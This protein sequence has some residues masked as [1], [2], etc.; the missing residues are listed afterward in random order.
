MSDTFTGRMML[1]VMG[2]EVSIVAVGTVTVINGFGMPSGMLGAG[3][4]G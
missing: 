1:V 2:T 3:S 4:G